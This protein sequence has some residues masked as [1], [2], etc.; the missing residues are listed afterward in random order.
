MVSI[1]QINNLQEIRRQI[2]EL[3]ILERKTR[4]VL[5]LQRELKDDTI[6]ING[7]G[8]LQLP[9]IYQYKKPNLVKKI[10]EKM[11]KLGIEKQLGII[12]KR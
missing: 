9:I 4:Y 8:S 11:D 12:Y 5:H 7:E 2:R 6:F 10:T 1:I 3:I